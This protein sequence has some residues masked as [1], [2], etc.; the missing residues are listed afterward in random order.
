MPAKKGKKKTKKVVGRIYKTRTGQPYK[1]L[2]SGKAMFVKRKKTG[3]AVKRKPAKRKAAKRRGGG[4]GLGRAISSVRS[5]VRGASSSVRGA[6][7]G[8]KAKVGSFLH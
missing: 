7:R 6:V 8:A 3:G 4:I 1:I 5:A 2:S